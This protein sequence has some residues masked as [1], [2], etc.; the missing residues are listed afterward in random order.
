[1]RILLTG[2]TG[3]L[4]SYLKLEADRPN[5]SEFDITN[6]VDLKKYAQNEYALIVHC[7]AYTDVQGAE[8]NK[9]SCFGVNVLG[10]LNLLEAFPDTPFVYISSEYVYKPVNFYSL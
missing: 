3:L 2:A 1:M 7:A 10:T 8:D 5:R 4:G 6:Y 9:S